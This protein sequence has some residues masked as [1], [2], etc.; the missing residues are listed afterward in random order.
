MGSMQGSSK[1]RKTF[2]IVFVDIRL[3][4]TLLRFSSRNNETL[5]VYLGLLYSVIINLEQN[6]KINF[7]T[8]LETEK[9]NF[10]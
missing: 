6:A 1:G 8:H 10:C 3:H 5:D 7:L 2:F 4:Q 9:F